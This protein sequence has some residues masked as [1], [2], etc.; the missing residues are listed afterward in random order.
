MIINGNLD[1]QYSNIKSLGKITEVKGYLDLHDSSIESLGKLKIVHGDLYLRNC[2]NLKDLGNLEMVGTE[3]ISE[4]K[5]DI[6]DI[7][8]LE[9]SGII[10][11]YIWENKRWLRSKCDFGY[12]D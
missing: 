7:I 2:R 1:L 4:D 9:G 6:D 3:N 8:S 11:D 5:D 10:E 12:D